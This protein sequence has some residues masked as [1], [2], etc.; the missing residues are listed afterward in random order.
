MAAPGSVT[1]LLWTG[2]AG[3]AGFLAVVLLEGWARP[4]YS[5]VRHPVSA[6][7]L[8]ARGVVQR[9]NFAVAGAAI[10]AGALGVIGQGTGQTLALGLLVAVFG[11]A[12]ALSAVPMDPGRGYPPG[13]PSGD[14][15]PPSRAHRIHDLA[16]AGVFFSLPIVAVV[17]VF[18]LPPWWMRLGSA[19]M[20]AWLFAALGLFSRAWEDRSPRA[21]LAQRAFIVPGWVWLASL[22][23]VFAAG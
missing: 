5:P 11:L 17:A 4:G 15:E 2:T 9:V 13:A 12:L 3:A 14:P 10:T 19:A 6:L 8:G 21:G 22:F 16:G 1:L 7:S 23:C 20:A 18:V